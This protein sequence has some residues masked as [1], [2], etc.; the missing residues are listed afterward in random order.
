MAFCKL[1][2]TVLVLLHNSGGL[3]GNEVR[4]SII[5]AEDAQKGMWP[6]MVHLNVTSSESKTVKWRCGGTI[7]A[8][9]W[10]LTSAQCVANLD[11]HRSFVAIG[12]YQLQKKSE[13]YMHI[14]NIVPY[15]PYRDLGNGNYKN[16][17][18]LIK[19]KKPI[20][21]SKDVAQVPLPDKDDTFGPSSECWI[22][23]WGEVGNGVPLKA[24]ET[25]QQ[26]K[27]SI[28]SQSTCKK[29]YS[30]LEP[31]TICTSD[32][33][34]RGACK[35]DY[36]GPLVCRKGGK[37]VQVGIMSSGGCGPNDRPGVCTEVAKY[38]TFINDFIHRPG[39]APAEM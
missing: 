36:G 26:L 11:F 34:G 21:F 3:L 6:W 14:G 18:A 24:P 33:K 4:S 38:L 30:E 7:V 13:R 2:L 1:L 35:G 16:D 17:I 10:V 20:A 32:S 15:V 37:L 19:L 9:Q 25:L 5:G 8:K 28:I 31:N 23:G 12:A 22:T 39:K 29:T 27:I